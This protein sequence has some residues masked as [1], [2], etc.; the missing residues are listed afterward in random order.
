[1]NPESEF[2]FVGSRRRLIDEIREKG[3]DDLEILQLFDRV[4]R[5]LFIPQGMWHRAYEDTPVPIGYG[6]TASQPSLQALYLSILRPEPDERVL[7]IG[8]GSGF[9]TALLALSAERVYSVERVREL[10]IRARRALDGL[11]I[12]NAALMVGDGTIGW[13][14]YAPY[15]VAVISAASPSVPA[16]LVDQLADPGRLLI[17]VG[18]REEQ[19]LILVRKAKGEIVEEEVGE[20][21]TFVPLLGRHGFE[22][23]EG[24]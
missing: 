13:R 21:C 16:A 7:E 3:I 11:E 19:E 1:M 10:S 22:G 4:P 23:E 20:R 5:H 17:P 2:R 18:N 12:H 6:Q 24:E 14:R 15:Q 8:T 9:L